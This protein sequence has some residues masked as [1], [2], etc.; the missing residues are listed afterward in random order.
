MNKNLVLKNRLPILFIFAFVITFGVT[1]AANIFVA[2]L[3]WRALN[4]GA[5][6]EKGKDPSNKFAV[7]R[8]KA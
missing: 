2:F 7:T 6:G 3:I 4:S 1:I 5:N 8:S